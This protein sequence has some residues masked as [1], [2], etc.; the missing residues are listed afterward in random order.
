MARAKKPEG[1]MV[2]NEVEDVA[3][4]WVVLGFLVQWEC[5]GLHTKRGGESLESSEQGSD[6][7]W[8][9]M[10]RVSLAAGLRPH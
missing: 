1:R 10:S 6:A 9:A 3:W 7:T 8:L 2:G 4:G 5:S